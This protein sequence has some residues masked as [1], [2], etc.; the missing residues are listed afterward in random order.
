M[1]MDT[2]TGLPYELNI[3]NAANECLKFLRHQTG[4]ILSSHIN[5]GLSLS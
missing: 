4:L 3:K 5:R 1:D 2:H